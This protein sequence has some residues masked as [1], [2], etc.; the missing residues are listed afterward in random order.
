MSLRPDRAYLLFRSDAPSL[1]P[2]FLRIPTDAETA[3]YEEAR[4]NAFIKAEPGLIRKRQQ[5]LAQKTEAEKAGLKFN[6]PIPPVPS[7]DTFDF[8]YDKIINA[9]TVGMGS[10]FERS[11]RDRTMLLEALPGDYVLYGIG[12]NDIFETCF[13]LGTVSFPAEAGKITDMGSLFIAG[14][15]PQSDIPELAGETG[16]GESSMSDFLPVWTAAIR[17]A[18]AS[19]KIPA[20][21]VD[22]PIVPAAYRAQG[23]FVAG[24]SFA[25]NRLAPIPGVLGYDRGKVIDLATGKV[26]PNQY[27]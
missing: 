15:G 10:T 7:L 25:I 1:S 21:L 24:F 16:F 18:N 19:T 11:D 23:K 12:W 14:A 20:L 17:P 4:R 22:K 8:A 26:A 27:D 2:V 6:K 5:L 9:Q 3:S 13:C